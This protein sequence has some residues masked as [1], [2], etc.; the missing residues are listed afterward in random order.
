[1]PLIQVMYR[2]RACSGS[3][4]DSALLGPIIAASTRNN[5]RDDVTGFLIAAETWFVQI[6]EGDEERVHAAYERIR[7]DTRH[8]DL[9]RIERREMAT[10]SFSDWTM[11]CSTDSL[12]RRRVFQR[13]GI[14]GRF[15]PTGMIAPALF[16]LALDLQ[17]LDRYYAGAQ[18]N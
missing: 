15:D 10:R 13:H 9:V 17:F 12:M 1:M 18:A 2:S 4:E 11:G 14:T 8:Y 5:A 6:L 7:A 16:A 3:A